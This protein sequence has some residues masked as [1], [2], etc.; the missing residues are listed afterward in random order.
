MWAKSV[1]AQAN[2]GD[3]INR[4]VFPVWNKTDDMTVVWTWRLEVVYDQV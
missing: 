1:T 2:T 3:L 4:K